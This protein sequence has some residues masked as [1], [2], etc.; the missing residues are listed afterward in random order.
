MRQRGTSPR[1][2]KRNA[3]SRNPKSRVCFLISRAALRR[4]TAPRESY[5]EGAPAEGS[6]AAIGAKRRPS[7]A[8][9]CFRLCPEA[10]I[11]GAPPTHSITSSARANSN[12]GIAIPSAFAVFRLTSGCSTQPARSRVACSRPCWCCFSFSSPASHFL[13][14]IVSTTLLRPTRAMLHFASH[15]VDVAAS[16]RWVSG[17][18]ARA[19]VCP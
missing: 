2:A 17:P 13:A 15:V 14:A 10:A 16:R 9:V 5:H 7:R 3:S 1:S 12:C 11:A 6:T 8:A 19:Y 18:A 4:R